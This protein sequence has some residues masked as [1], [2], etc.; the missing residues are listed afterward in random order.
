[1]IKSD[2]DMKEITDAIHSSGFG[3]SLQYERQISEKW[4]VGGRFAYLDCSVGI[5]DEEVFAGGESEKLTLDMSLVSFSLEIHAR[6]FPFTGTFFVDGM[7]GYGSLAVEINGGLF[8]TTSSGTKEQAELEF[9]ASRNYLKY[10][11]K[12]GWRIDFGKPGGF[13]FEPSLGYYGAVGIGKTIAA[14]VSD[15]VGDGEADYNFDNA[16]N[17]LENFIFIGGP[18]LSLSFGWRF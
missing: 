10:G 11:I 17:L 6:Y 14:Q 2:E 18:R 13:V 16:F 15:E 12:T 3:I 5:W 7:M 8:I 9:T 1:M 4:S